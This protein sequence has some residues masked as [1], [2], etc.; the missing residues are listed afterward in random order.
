MWTSVSSVSAQ[1]V[2]PMQKTI[3]S[4]AE[5]FIVQISIQ[6]PYKSAQVSQIEIFDENWRPMRNAFLSQK[7]ALLGSGH[8]LTITAL[9]PFQGKRQTHVY[10]CHSITPR[11]AGKGS[12]Y[13]GEVC[14][15][16]TARRLSA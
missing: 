14:G 5:N 1:S 10:I 16:Y 6:N 2:S 11:V 13:K 9:V 7:Q 15:K 12:A 4:F 8:N 3:N